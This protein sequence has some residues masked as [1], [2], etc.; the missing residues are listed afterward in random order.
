MENHLKVKGLIL[1]GEEAVEVACRLPLVEDN[2]KPRQMAGEQ[3]ELC[4]VRV[5]GRTPGPGMGPESILSGGKEDAQWLFPLSLPGF[6]KHMDRRHT[7]RFNFEPVVELMQTFL[8]LLQNRMG[9]QIYVK[10]VCG[11]HQTFSG[12]LSLSCFRSL[13]TCRRS[14]RKIKNALNR[15][16]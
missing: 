4:T 13:R 6:Q 9:S 11:A 7:D 14:I 12:A 2:R 1:W 5:S 3:M 10:A 15:L 8:F 16:T